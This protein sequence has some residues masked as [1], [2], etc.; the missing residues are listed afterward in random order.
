[1]PL[2]TSYPQPTT[3]GRSLVSLVAQAAQARLDADPE[4]AAL[5]EP[6]RESASGNGAGGSLD[7]FVEATTAFALEPWQRHI[8]A[9]LERLRDG[10]AQR[11]LIHGPPQ[12]GKSIIISQRFPAWLLMAEPLRR[13]RVAC[14]NVSHA[15]RFTAACLSVLQDAAPTLVPRIA[16]KAEWS[17]HARAALNDANPSMLALGLGTGF[18]GLGVDDLIIDDPYKNIQEARSPAHNVMLRDWYQNVVLSRL[19]PQ[20][21]VVVMF[22]RWW[23]GDFAGWLIEQGG[24]EVIRFPA[25]ADGKPHDPTGRPV[26]EIL[27][28]RYTLE[29]LEA[30]RAA[31]GT[32]FEALYQ[33][34]PYP[35]EGGLFKAGRVVFVD[36]APQA[37][38]R[39]RRWDIGATAGGGDYTTGVLMYK[40]LRYGVEDVVRGQWDTDRRDAVIRETAERD[41][42]RYG[43]A[44]VTHVLPQDPGAAGKSQALAFT[45]LLAGLSVET[46]RE[47]GDKATRADPFSSQWNAGNVEVVRAPWNRAYLDEVL[48]FPNGKHD[49]QVDGS[50]GA[51][52]RLAI[53]PRKAIHS[54]SEAAW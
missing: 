2:R 12:F 40:G 54:T 8:C 18:T 10:T 32:A 4:L 3:R 17:T 36:E 48:A 37:A 21:N 7:A 26:G 43:R 39:V 15:E 24:W 5:A 45:R 33:G 9:R 44:G 49:D 19:N 30:K 27:S 11:I 42:A 38:P 28:P 29:T 47:T 20:A 6:A 16:P 22:H 31:M 53:P 14:Y 25:I 41:A 50:S 34:T 35:A 13:V 46:E 52:N 1:M 51:F 23:E